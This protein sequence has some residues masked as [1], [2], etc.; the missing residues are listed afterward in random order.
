M[1][2]PSFHLSG[3][4]NSTFYETSVQQ[5]SLTSVFSKTCYCPRL[6]QFVFKL[7]RTLGFC[8]ASLYVSLPTSLKAAV[9]GMHSE[10]TAGHLLGVR[11]N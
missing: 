2:L 8:R 5:S 11:Q 3:L 1:V 6:G 7:S 10:A 9:A 4:I